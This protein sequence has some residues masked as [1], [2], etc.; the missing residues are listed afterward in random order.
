MQDSF[1]LSLGPRQYH[2]AP[3]EVAPAATSERK[4][5]KQHQKQELQ[6]FLSTIPHKIPRSGGEF[7]LF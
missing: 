1:S 4:M 2:R 5:S 6:P 7:Q 3:P